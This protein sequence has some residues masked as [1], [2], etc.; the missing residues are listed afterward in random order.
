MSDFVELKGVL[1]KLSKKRDVVFVKKSESWLMKLIG[2]FLY[3]IN[4]EFNTKFTTT[5]GNRIYHPGDSVNTI[6][7]AHELVHIEDLEPTYKKIGYLMPQLLF[8]IGFAGFFWWPLFV[9]F[10][11][12][13]PWPSPWRT[14]A[15]LKGYAMS[16][17]ARKIAYNQSFEVTAKYYSEHFTSSKY[18]WMSWDTK[19]DIEF[20]LVLHAEN[21]NKLEAFKKVRDIAK[22]S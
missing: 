3:P 21:L 14:Q 4:K 5:I 17:L 9:F 16:M 19:D 20:M 15:E 8:V 22:H 12:I 18:Y 1:E 11:F 6:T 10:V 2:I 7:L 13:F